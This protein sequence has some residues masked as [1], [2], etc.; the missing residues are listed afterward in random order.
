MPRDVAKHGVAKSFRRL[1]TCYEES[2]YRGQR[3]QSSVEFAVSPEG[4]I[5]NVDFVEPQDAAARYAACIQVAF[6]RSGFPR[7]PGET[8]LNVVMSFSPKEEALK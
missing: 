8:R 1:V 4:G 3:T 5:A 6:L 7:S 2:S